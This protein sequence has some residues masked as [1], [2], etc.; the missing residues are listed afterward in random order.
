MIHSCCSVKCQLC[1]NSTYLVS[2]LQPNSPSPLL[3]EPVPAINISAVT[4]PVNPGSAVII[5]CSSTGS[6][7]TVVR[8]DGVEVSTGVAD[9]TYMIDTFDN[10][11]VGTYDC[12]AE[13]PIGRA[14][15]E[16]L[17]LNTGEVPSVHILFITENYVLLL[18]LLFSLSLIHP[19]THTHT[20][21]HTHNTH[22]TSRTA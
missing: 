13:N 12:L 10:G 17:L 2:Y 8:K 7:V 5:T 3:V 9:A 22:V 11:D 15:S 21:T 14:L 4:R 19:H 6:S 1:W 16:G 18:S 20:H